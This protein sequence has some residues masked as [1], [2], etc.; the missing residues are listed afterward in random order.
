MKRGCSQRCPCR[1]AIKEELLNELVEGNSSLEASKDRGFTGPPCAS[2]ISNGQEKRSGEWS[3]HE[4]KQLSGLD[5]V[6]LSRSFAAL[7]L[8]GEMKG[9]VAFGQSYFAIQAFTS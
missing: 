1:Q 4:S 9:R 8:Q 2:E 5:T 6:S 3:D 7:L